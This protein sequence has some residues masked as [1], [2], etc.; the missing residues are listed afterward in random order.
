MAKQFEIIALDRC[1]EA[2]TAY[3][4]QLDRQIDGLVEQLEL[5]QAVRH[6]VARS[7]GFDRRAN[8]GPLATVLDA[9]QRSNYEGT[10]SDNLSDARKAV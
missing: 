1:T 7:H 8:V 3:V 4:A 2:A 5:A 6:A 9:A 10:P